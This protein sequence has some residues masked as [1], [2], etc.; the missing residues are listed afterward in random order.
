MNISSSFKP[1]FES[2][3]YKA[4]LEQLKKQIKELI[5][6][7]PNEFHPEDYYLIR[8]GKFLA[9]FNVIERGF[10]YIG[11]NFRGLEM[12]EPT[13]CHNLEANSIDDIIKSVY[14]SKKIF[15]SHPLSIMFCVLIKEI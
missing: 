14:D 7:Y 5:Y 8:M 4:L 1:D 11:L 3:L 13:S 12:Q 2:Y 6:R 9:I 10:N 15:Y